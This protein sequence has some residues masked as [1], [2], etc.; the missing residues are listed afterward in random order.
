MNSRAVLINPPYPEG[1]VWVREGRCQQRDI[2]RAPFRPYSLAMISSQL[3]KSGFDTLLID[4][5]SHQKDIETVL[6]ECGK[7]NPEIVFIAVASPT[8]QFD[9]GWFLPRL[10]KLLPTITAVAI[11]VHV[12]GFPVKVLEEYSALDCA[13]IGEPEI[14]ARELATAP[15]E[16]KSLELVSGLGWRDSEGNIRINAA[17]GFTS[18][19]DSLGLPDWKDLDVSRYRMPIKQRPFSLIGFSRGCPFLCKYCTARTYGGNFLRK[20]SVESLIEEIEYNISLGVSDFL[21]W[22]ELMTLDENHLDKF[23]EE[24][25]A[26]GFHKRISWVCNSRVDSGSLEM[27]R[28]MKRAGCWQIAFGFEF[29]D[30]DILK[31]SGK[32]GRATVEQGRRTAALANESGLVLDGHFILG[33][34]GETEKTIQKTIDYACSLPLTFAHFYAATPFPGSALYDEAVQSG[35]LKETYP[36]TFHQDESCLC[37]DFLEAE[38]VN[39]Y[40]KAAYRTFYLRPKIVWRGLSIPSRPREYFNLLGLGFQF[41]RSVRK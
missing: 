8:I 41:Y 6:S 16:G 5:G 25:L 31:L 10:K 32:G 1:K 40:I 9:L 13:V 35:W 17:R 39:K 3:I 20:R 38:T 23:L 18:D 4:S 7:F 28:K 22:T 19:L 12:S 24:L 14:T 30:D 29:G 26:R 27:F 11:G 21:F 2:W 33:Y 34:P 36:G 37:T 15:A